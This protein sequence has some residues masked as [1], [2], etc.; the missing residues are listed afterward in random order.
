MTI[1]DS[2]Q[3]DFFVIPRNEG[4][5]LRGYLRAATEAG[6]DVLLLTSFNEWPETTVVEPSSSWPDPYLYLKIVAAWKNRAF[7]PPPVPARNH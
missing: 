6:A 7:V 5:T 3:P 1:A 2:D 4:D